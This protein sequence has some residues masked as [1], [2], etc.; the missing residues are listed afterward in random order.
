MWKMVVAVWA[1]A[2]ITKL[3]CACTVPVAE[4]LRALQPPLCVQITGSGA[5]CP[6]TL[7]WVFMKGG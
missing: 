3:G 5:G 7:D 1:G 6:Y 4:V 2:G